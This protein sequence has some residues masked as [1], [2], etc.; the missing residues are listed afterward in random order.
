MKVYITPAGKTALFITNFLERPKEEF[1]F[2]L[3]IMLSDSAYTND[4]Y[5]KYKGEVL[6]IIP[7]KNPYFGVVDYMPTVHRIIKQTLL[8]GANPEQIVINSSGGTEKMTNII[9][10]AGDILG[11]KYPIL[12]VFGVYDKASKDVI[13]TTKPAFDAREVLSSVEMDVEFTL[14]L[15]EQ[16]HGKSA[17]LDVD[18]EFD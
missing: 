18:P 10:D 9:K 5:E 15:K 11:L 17:D 1:G 14:S 16:L 3:A 6:S 2:D 12:R 4:L 8:F 13:F 7:I